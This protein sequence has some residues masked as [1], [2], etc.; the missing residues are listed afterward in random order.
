MTLRI[1][2]RRPVG[3]ASRNCRH[4][5]GFTRRRPSR[6]WPP[7]CRTLVAYFNRVYDLYGRHVELK[8]YNGQGDFL[9][10]FQ[11]Q[12]IQGAQADGARARDLGAFADVSI[13]TMTQPYSEALVSQ[14]IIVMSPVYLSDVW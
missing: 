10:E 14:R 9:A 4:R 1:S 5:R 2:E 3:G 13:V 6:A 12:N 7:T 8:V 11:N